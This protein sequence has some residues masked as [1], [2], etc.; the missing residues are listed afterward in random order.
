VLA[1]KNVILYT[2]TV[3]NVVLTPVLIWH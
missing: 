3:F 1:R 2:V